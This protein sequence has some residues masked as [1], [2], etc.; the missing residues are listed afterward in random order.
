M[1]F[2]GRDSP[3]ASG[4]GW[5][6]LISPIPSLM[7]MLNQRSV[8]GSGLMESRDPVLWYVGFAGLF[9]VVGSIVCILRLSHSL[10]DRS[11]SQG[12]ITDDQSAVGSCQLGES[13]SWS[14]LS[15]DRPEFRR[16]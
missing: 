16:L 9:I 5:L 12:F 8:G 1:L 15:G 3:I 6:K 4:A 13:C 11:R 7:Q 14:I 2:E 10:L